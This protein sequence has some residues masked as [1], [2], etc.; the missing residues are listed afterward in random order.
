MYVTTLIVWELPGYR[1]NTVML[2]KLFKARNAIRGVTHAR[3]LV[4]VFNSAWVAM[5]F[6]SADLQA[7]LGDNN[8]NDDNWAFSIPDGGPR[9]SPPIQPPLSVEGMK[10]NRVIIL[11]RGS[12]DPMDEGTTGQYHDRIHENTCSFWFGMLTVTSVITAALSPLGLEGKLESRSHTV[13][14]IAIILCSKGEFVSSACLDGR[15]LDSS[16]SPRLSKHPPSTTA[17][18]VIS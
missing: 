10:L 15:Y 14:G 7:R 6:S 16:L 8:N 3:L 1:F 2:F 11:E 12:N 9:S 17:H 4:S 5:L 18:M 13:V